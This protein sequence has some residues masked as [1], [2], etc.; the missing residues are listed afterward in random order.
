MAMHG[1]T[2]SV[3]FGTDTKN[4]SPRSLANYIRHRAD[5]DGSPIRLL[6]CDTGKAVDEEY[7]FAEEL[8][9]CLGVEVMAP[10]DKLYFRKDGSFYIGLNENGIMRVFAPNERRRLK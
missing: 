6:S 9:N 2:D 8:S 1:T 10:T 5:Y 3:C 4:M 7:C